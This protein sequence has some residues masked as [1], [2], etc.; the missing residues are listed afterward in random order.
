MNEA[1]REC[2]ATMRPKPCAD[3]VLEDGQR[4]GDV[5][6]EVRLEARLLLAFLLASEKG[7][8]SAQK[9]QLGPCIPVGIQL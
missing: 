6:A 9:M 8:R 3:R 7:V 2:K 4:L 1:E 5:G